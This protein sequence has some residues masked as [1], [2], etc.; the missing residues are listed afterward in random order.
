M[1]DVL[2][3]RL[4][5]FEQFTHR[6]IKKLPTVYQEFE[7]NVKLTMEDVIAAIQDQSSIPEQLNFHRLFMTFSWGTIILF[8]YYLMYLQGSTALP[9]LLDFIIDTSSAVLL[10]YI[11]IPAVLYFRL[12]EYEEY[13]RKSRFTLLVAAIFQGLL[14]GFLQCDC[15]T[16]IH[17]PVEVI[18]MLFVSTISRIC[19]H[20][21]N[22]DRQAYFGIVNGIGFIFVILIGFIT[23][24][25]NKAYVFSTVLAVFTS[26]V[27]I[28]VYMRR[29]MQCDLRPSY[30]LLMMMV[31]SI[32]CQTLTRMLFGKYKQSR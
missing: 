12:A 4:T 31:M 22:N 11:I 13:S 15:S 3:K 32:Y 20:K 14:A 10:T 9:L 17:L 18:N 5:E 30:L 16:I 27:V 2:L 28:Q 26:H 6:N 19:G 8:A 21:L 29:V 1:Y 23:R 25:L 7:A 24:Q